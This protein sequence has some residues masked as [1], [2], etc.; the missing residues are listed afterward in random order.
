MGSKDTNPSAL[1]AQRVAW[2]ALIGAIIIMAMKFAVFAM[3]RSAAVLSDAMESVVNIA[4]AAMATFSTWYAARPADREHPYGHGNIEFISVGVEGTMIAI[5]GLV[6]IAESVRRLWLGL[7][8]EQLDAGMIGLGVLNVL[9]FALALYIRR[10]A[11]DIG[12]PTLIADGNHLLVDCL[13][14]L[15][16]IAALAAVHFTGWV[17]LDAVA[18][19]VMAIVIVFAG[20][21]LIRRSLAGLM[22]E[23]DLAEHAMIGRLLDARV[24]AG[25]I[26]SYHKLRHRHVGTYHWVDLHIQLPADMTVAAAHERASAI[27]YEIEQSL[28]QAIATAHIEPPAT[29]SPPHPS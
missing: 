28:G 12:S 7:A 26:L 25:D 19:I 23:S 4:A 20:C 6:I 17:W 21:R 3:T 8:P 2:I 27:E 9:L 22:D 24:G 5:A 11:A 10:R 29:T 15:A 1:A 16:I 18:G 13:T 14:T